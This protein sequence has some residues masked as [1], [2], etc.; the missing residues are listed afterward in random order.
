MSE[1]DK[2]FSKWVVG[3]CKAVPERM[4]R[5]VPECRIYL[6]YLEKQKK[7]KPKNLKESVEKIEKSEDH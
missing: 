7:P 3:Y 2:K 1:N 4:A 6:D 5:K